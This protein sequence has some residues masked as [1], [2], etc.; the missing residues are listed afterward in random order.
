MSNGDK[1]E[2]DERGSTD[3]S[4]RSERR[5]TDHELAK[6]ALSVDIVAT[7]VVTKARDTADAL[8]DATRSD[9]D[10]DDA[11]DRTPQNQRE[12]VRARSV[13]DAEIQKERHSADAIAAD[14]HSERL[15]ALARLLAHERQDTDLKLELE[16]LR[17]DAELTSRE[18]FMA[19]VSHD[20]RSLLGAIALSAEMLT[21]VETRPDP[22]V[23]V[24]DYADRIQR[25]TARMH[26]IVGDLMDVASIEAGK[27]AIVRTSRDVALLLRDAVDAFGATA[28]TQDITLTTA[29]SAPGSINVDHE[30][31]FQVLTNL[32]G[33]ALKFTP[34]GGSIGVRVERDATGATFTVTDTGQ[35]I[36]ADLLD[37]IF[38]RFVQAVETDRRGLGLGLFIAKSIVDAHGGTIG[39]HSTVGEG[40]TFS[41]TLPTA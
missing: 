21:T 7:D 24:R 31:I 1:R 32:V 34:R 16:R 30:R 23:K 10:R 8:L 12:L 17:A 38:G 28:A 11:D 2:G 33:N 19:I 15:V 6:N 5:K 3:Q 22:F 20:L 29:C 26:R 18:D 27:L 14:E 39:V 9:E 4:L 36:H 35:G 37:T 40:S 41:F 13:A 25:F